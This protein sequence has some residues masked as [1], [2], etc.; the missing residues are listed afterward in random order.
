MRYPT[1]KEGPMP[2]HLSPVAASFSRRRLVLGAAAAAAGL[3]LTPSLAAA[4]DGHGDHDHA[5][6]PIP[7]PIPGGLAIGPPLETIHVWAAGKTGITLP[8]SG[9]TLQGI[10]TEPTTMGDFNGVSAVAFHVGTATD[11]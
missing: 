2:A 5:S 10:G 6:S 7:K 1:S 8:F 3:T 9:A 4:D 11:R